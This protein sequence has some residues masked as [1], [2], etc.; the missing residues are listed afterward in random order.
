VSFLAMSAVPLLE[1]EGVGV[2]YRRGAHAVDA[3]RGVSLQIGAGER[4]GLVG[5]SGSGKSTL[6][7]VMLGL[8][9]PHRGAVHFDGRP[10]Y[11]LP[12]AAYRVLRRQVQMVFQDPIGSLNARISVGD[13][14]REVL[15]VHRIV[16]ADQYEQRVAELLRRVGLDPALAP[17]YP[18]EFSGGQRQRVALARALAVEPRVLV[19][20]EPVSALD[21]SVQV[22]I[23]NLLSDLNRQQGV[24]LLLI[25]HDLAVVRYSCDRVYVMQQGLVVEEGPVSRVLDAPEHPYTRQLLDAVPDLDAALELTP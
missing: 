18:H 14:L 16:P 20:D 21:V 15:E 19:A 2:T 24:A 9:K 11:G 25:A 13:A 1:A 10:V 6:A 23:L 8:E 5:E 4:V 3:L 7:R 22:Q 12:R 17:R